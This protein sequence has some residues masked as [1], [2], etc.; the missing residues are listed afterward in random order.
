MKA[1]FWISLFCFIGSFVM[2]SDNEIESG[3][4]Y[5]ILGIILMIIAIRLFVKKNKKHPEILEQKKKKLIFYNELDENDTDPFLM[6][7]IDAV[8]DL[9]QASASFIQRRFKIGYARAGRIIDQMED[10]GIVSGY[11]GSKPRQVLISKKQWEELKTTQ[12]LSN[13]NINK[14]EDETIQKPYE[15][16]MKMH[17]IDVVYNNDSRMLES[18]NNSLILENTSEND[19]CNFINTLLKYNKPESLKIVLI[20]LNGLEFNIYNDIPHMLIPLIRETNKAIGTLAWAAQEMNNRLEMFVKIKAKNI[21]TYNEL[22]ETIKLPYII[23]IIDE[24]YELLNSFESRDLLIKVLLNCERT[25]IKIIAY[26]K[27]S[28]RNLNTKTIEDLFKVYTKDGPKLLVKPEDKGKDKMIMIDSNMNGFDFEKYAGEILHNNG[29]EEIEITKQS[30]DF[31][32]DIIAYK[33]D[34]KYAI[35]CKKY[36]SMVGIKAV[37]E[38]IASKAM[39]NCHVAVVITNN[40]FT[41]SAKELAEKNNVLLWDRDKLIDLINDAKQ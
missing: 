13:N 32:V 20:E 4:G 1:C 12:P 22:N 37:Q 28:R 29:F 10:R 24:I 35:Q 21:Q 38:V 40:Y 7:A 14:N 6:D 15:Q 34:V 5:L 25:G 17:G 19:K 23:I 2:F 36:S 26:S 8:V 41:N 30:G 39:N 27:F 33:D 31:G 3:S 11:E 18:L 16:V 9:G